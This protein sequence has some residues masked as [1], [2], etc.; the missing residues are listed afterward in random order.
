MK[1][2]WAAAMAMAATIGVASGAEARI[3]GPY[4]SGNLSIF[5]IH[6]E[7]MPGGG[8]A[9]AYLTLDEALAGGLAAVYETGDVNELQVE[10]KSK[11]RTLFIQAGDIVKGGRQDRV[12]SV[13]LILPPGSGKTAITAFCVEQGR[14]SARAGE[15]AQQ[16]A[17]A[18]KSLAGKD[19]KL[20]AKSA[21][22]QT[23]VWNAVAET[24]AKL[25]ASVGEEVASPASPTSLQL[26]LENKTLTEAIG[27]HK[28]AL[29]DLAESNPD[30][31]GYVYAINGKIS[32]GDL[33]ASPALFRKLWPRLLEASV[34]EAVAE[35][36]DGAA[37][38][39]AAADDVA[40]FLAA[41][42]GA[43]STAQ[44]LPAGVTLVSRET[45]KAAAFETRS[46][47]AEGWLHRSYIV[48]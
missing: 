25:A 41:M 26:S 3:S 42:D 2:V 16:F 44:E 40:A 12:L 9:G 23:E 38:S 28:A 33:Y 6:A 47:A 43:A 37:G 17:S 36:A 11:D 45:E 35:A 10:N 27:K 30:A 21:R 4:Q 34:T 19:L 1:A 24:Q 20:A 48:K 8:A 31:S 7:P 18:E 39:G 14:W 5:L 15:S 32:G 46:A 22:S 29:A 13:D